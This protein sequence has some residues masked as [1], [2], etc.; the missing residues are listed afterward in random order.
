MVR[1]AGCRA[2]GGSFFGHSGLSMP[3]PPGA[4]EAST[5]DA[6]PSATATSNAF[7]LLRLGNTRR[8]DKT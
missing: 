7:M 3:F 1:R 5:N 6:S 4:I 2:S 8:A